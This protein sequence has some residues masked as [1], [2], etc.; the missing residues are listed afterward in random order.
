MGQ[1]GGLRLIVFGSRRGC[2][3]RDPSRPGAHAPPVVNTVATKYISGDSSRKQSG[4]AQTC[5]DSRTDGSI[6]H[7]VQPF[8]IPRTMWI[9]PILR[10]LS[11]KGSFHSFAS[12]SK[13]RLIVVMLTTFGPGF[14]AGCGFVDKLRWV[15]KIPLRNGLRVELCFGGSCRSVFGPSVA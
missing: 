8:R 11:C 7:R 14:W 15:C 6:T 4:T 10:A 2:M 1:G 3:Q 12:L 5:T 13:Q 9:R